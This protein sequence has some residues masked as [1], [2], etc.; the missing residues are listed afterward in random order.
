[1]KMLQ[2]HTVKLRETQ[3]DKVVT[4]NSTNNA[5]ISGDEIYPG[6]ICRRTKCSLNGNLPEKQKNLSL[7]CNC[8]SSP[9]STCA[10]PTMGQQQH[11]GAREQYGIQCHI[12]V[13]EVLLEQ[14]A[15]NC[16]KIWTTWI[17][18]I[19]RHFQEGV[20]RFLEKFGLKIIIPIIV[21]ILNLIPMKKIS[22]KH[23]PGKV[24]GVAGVDGKPHAHAHEDPHP[25]Q[26]PCLHEDDCHPCEE[27]HFHLHHQSHPC[28]ALTILL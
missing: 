17:S 14:F 27:N 16:H 24:C 12:A 19:S 2:L 9:T 11:L 3:H 21:K 10:M 8:A 7:M 13:S 26:H 28:D 22:C 6:A 18:T 23:N 1:M 15:T 25:C 5:T 4:N 20:S